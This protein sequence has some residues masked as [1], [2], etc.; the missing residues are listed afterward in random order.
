MIHFNRNRNHDNAYHIST[1]SYIKQVWKKKDKVL[2]A[3]VMM[4]ITSYIW[5]S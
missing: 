1:I 4:E 3:S 2:L 5:D